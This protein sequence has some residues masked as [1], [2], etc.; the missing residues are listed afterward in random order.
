MAADAVHR[1]HQSLS[2]SFQ[3]MVSLWVKVS[4]IVLTCELHHAS[5]VYNGKPL[6]KT[7]PLEFNLDIE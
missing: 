7:I 3:A 2:T 6:P 4:K 5:D 1:A